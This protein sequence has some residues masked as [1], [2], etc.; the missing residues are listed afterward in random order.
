MSI[1]PPPIAP[2]L[3]AEFEEA[4]QERVRQIIAAAVGDEPRTSS[5][6]TSANSASPR[7]S[8]KLTYGS[9]AP[10]RWP[11]PDRMPGGFGEGACSARSAATQRGNPTWN[12][13]HPQFYL[14]KSDAKGDFGETF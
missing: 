9:T 13:T 12:M 1:L 4:A 8:A 5:P 2:S 6:R 11:P 14:S 7:A 10:K 3:Q